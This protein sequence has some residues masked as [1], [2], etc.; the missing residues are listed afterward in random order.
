MRIESA[1]KTDRGYVRTN[2]EDGLL[3]DDRLGIYAVADGMGGHR[4]GEIASRLTLEALRDTLER[5]GGHADPA[6]ALGRALQTAGIRILAES[7]ADPQ[8]RG[9]GTTLT[10]L[11]IENGR[12]TLVHVGDSRCYRLRGGAFELLTEDHSWVWEQRKLGLISEADTRTHPMRNVITRSVGHGG[13]SH[14]DILPVDVQPGDL[15]VLCTDGL[16]GYVPDAEIAA[17]VDAHRN[18]PAHLVDRLI[19]LALQHGGEDNVSAVA[20]RLL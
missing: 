11:L 2:N 17:V 20:L 12:G 5:E 15:Y 1:G 8:L 7:Q 18:E 13:E 9:M 10:A 19:D 4:A 16:C 14:P 6:I 3:V